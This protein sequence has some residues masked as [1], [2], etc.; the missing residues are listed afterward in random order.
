[1]PSQSV[2]DKVH[3]LQQRY[4]T[5]DAVVDEDPSEHEKLAVFQGLDSLLG[6]YGNDQEGDVPN[7]GV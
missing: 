7:F 4:Y 5:L 1:M 3:G 2:P 6:V